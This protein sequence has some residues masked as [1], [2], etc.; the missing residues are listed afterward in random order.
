MP[1]GHG[2]KDACRLTIFRGTLHKTKK[3]ELRTKAESAGCNWVDVRTLSGPRL[4]VG[5]GRDA[6]AISAGSS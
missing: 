6:G 1:S 2:T 5:C 4:E 3:E